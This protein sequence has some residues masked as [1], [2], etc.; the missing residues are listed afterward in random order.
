MPFPLVPA[1]GAVAGGIKAISGFR[2]GARQRERSQTFMSKLQ[3][4]A[5]VTESE[6]EYIKKQ[7]QIAEGG[8]PFQN[9]MMQEQMNRVVGNIRQTGAENMQRT[10]GSIIRQ[11]MESSIVAAELRRKTAD[12][13]LRSVAEQSRR[14]AAENRVAQERTKREAEEKALRMQMAVDDRKRSANMQVAQMQSQMPSRSELDFNFLTNLAGVGLQ[15]GSDYSDW[16]LGDKKEW[17]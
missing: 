12:T 9:Q 15:F 10:E 17:P 3:N 11:G 2:A 14:I 16:N 8:D 5:N 13:T 4:L 6:R 1:L 7:R